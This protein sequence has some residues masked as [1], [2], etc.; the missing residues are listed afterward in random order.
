LNNNL[1]KQDYCANIR[2]LIERLRNQ[3]KH[4]VTENELRTLIG[5]SDAKRRN[6]IHRLIQEGVLL[7]LKRELYCLAVEYR[8]CSL[9]PF[10]IAQFIYGP[11]YVSLESALSFHQLIPEAV[12]VITCVAS[13]RSRSFRTPEGVFNYRKTP[14]SN[15][16]CQV[17]RYC[18]KD[19]QFLIAK[20]FKALCDY[21]YCYKKEYKSL[22][23]LE[24]DIRLDLDELPILLSDEKQELIKYYN[25]KRIR[26]FIKLFEQGK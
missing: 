22:S 13:K 23:A 21:V 19:Y 11:S 26:E 10:H 3:V 15:L 9:H 7:K 5:G 17:K 8:S 18:N 12:K 6:Q 2:K 14:L 25:S 1:I 16:Y 4:V 24:D 20:P